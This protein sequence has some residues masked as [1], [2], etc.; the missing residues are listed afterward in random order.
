MATPITW[1]SIAR[2]DF[3]SVNKGLLQTAALFNSAVDGFKD[4]LKEANATVQQNWNQG[5]E[6]NTNALLNKFAGF[7][8]AEEA[9][10]ALDSGAVAE[11]LGGYGAQVDGSAIRAAQQNLVSNLQKKAIEADTYQQAQ[12]AASERDTI[13]AVRARIAVGDYEGANSLMAESPLS[14]A[15]Q[16]VLSKDIFNHQQ[17][18][19]EAKEKREAAASTL[20]TQA[21]QRDS[22][23]TTA[24]T[25][26]AQVNVAQT[27]AETN[28]IRASNDLIKTL[29]A[30]AKAESDKDPVMGL[31]AFSTKEGI[32]TLKNELKLA[33]A[34]PDQ[35]QKFLNVISRMTSNGQYEYTNPDTKEKV[36]VNVP[37]SVLKDV[38][39]DSTSSY[40]FDWPFFGSKRNFSSF[41]DAVASS[42]EK[43][44]HDA[45]LRSQLELSAARDKEAEAELKSVVKAAR[46]AKQRVESTEVVKNQLK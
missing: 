13:G 4:P 20:L 26:R 12:L 29:Q 5:K 40:G 44:M 6:N 17:V 21:A 31:G 33:G 16:A 14:K 15:T 43:R 23:K 18:V 8:T 38:F 11:M 1:Q 28:E 42:F 19:A 24:E 10:A 37:V 35:Q 36:K 7:K 22:W 39:N 25:Q 27:N 41:E 3:D 2:P 9:Q 32:S 45:H 46:E 30:V 34:V